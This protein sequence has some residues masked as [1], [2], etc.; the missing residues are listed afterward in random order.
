MTRLLKIGFCAA[1]LAIL[2]MPL[3]IVIGVSLNEKRV[4]FFPPRGISGQW[5]A[6]LFVNPGW[7]TPLV[8][9]LGIATA[10]AAAAVLIALP[11][12]YYLRMQ[13]V[14]YAKALF[15][16]GLMPFAFPPVIT[17]MGMLLFWV[18]LGHFGQPDNIVIGHAV[19][20]VAL[21]L[22]MVS[23]GF[24]AIDEEVLEAAKTLG[25]DRLRIF[26]TV[27]FPLIRPFLISGFAFVFV[28][29]LN[30]FVI[31][32]FLGQSRVV[33]LPV[34]IFSSLRSGYSPS[35]ASASVL[36]IAISFVSFGLI[37]VF[38]NLTRLMGAYEDK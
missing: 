34:K 12:A 7:F 35:V 9:S 18:G 26:T 8:T 20:L 23:L 36:F 14:F 24:E 22:T 31:S 11:I 17:A 3:I 38:G 27:V 4:L 29:S 1:F 2:I 33:T 15:G 32:F 16:L 10:A 5:Y 13:K 28:L 21:P 6:E 25:A 30:E 19:F 37:G